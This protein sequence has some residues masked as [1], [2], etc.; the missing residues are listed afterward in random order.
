MI[1]QKRSLRHQMRRILAQLSKPQQQEKSRAACANLVRN[2]AFQ[3]ARVVMV[4]LSLA[5]E[6]DP[7]AAAEWALADGKTVA[8]PKIDWPKQLL[9]PVEYAGPG[10]P[11][12][13]DRH[14]L[15]HPADSVP[16]SIDRIDLIVTPGL[17]FDRQGNRLGRG[18][19]F[20]DR[21]FAD[22]LCRGLRLGFCWAEQITT[23][24]PAEEKDTKM[25][26]L[27]SDWE[28]ITVQ[29]S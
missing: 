4:F 1:D 11:L 5:D 9:V 12:Q 10:A 18:K 25:H 8:V 19:G 26:L 24:V 22:P 23:Q 21:F 17:A 14:G 15:R 27:I 6:I 7:A 28:S 13:Q 20:Y 16:V 3:T 29:K 2:P